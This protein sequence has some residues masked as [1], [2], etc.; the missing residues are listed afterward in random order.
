MRS[1]CITI[2][3]SRGRGRQVSERGTRGEHR[4]GSIGVCVGYRRKNSR[5]QIMSG[6]TIGSREDRCRVKRWRRRLRW[7][8]IRFTAGEE[9]AINQAADFLRPIRR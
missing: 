9:G 3:R 6:E 8:V 4:V 2:T 5:P 1:G 7:V